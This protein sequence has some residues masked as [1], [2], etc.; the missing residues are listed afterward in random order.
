[1]ATRS[2]TAS[3]P[4]RG[5]AD[6]VTGLP[7]AATAIE[8]PMPVEQPVM[9]QPAR[10]G[11]HH[12][13]SGSRRR[14]AA[15]RPLADRLRS[16]AVTHVVLSGRC[17]GEVGHL[18]ELAVGREVVVGPPARELG[19][20]QGQDPL[21]QVA[22]I[23]PVVDSRIV[24]REHVRIGAVGVWHRLRLVQ[25]AGAVTRSSVVPQMLEIG[26]TKYAAPPS[27]TL[28]TNASSSRG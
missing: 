27:L 13:S 2:A 10:F 9:S 28:I 24:R 14:Y 20:A 4:A 19:H 12:G 23:E 8:R 25:R 5:D 21:R 7:S 1:M 6:L 11:P 17:V 18:H 16:A 3:R 22:G 26:T 15:A